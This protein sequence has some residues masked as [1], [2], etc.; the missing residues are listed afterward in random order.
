MNKFPTETLAAE[1]KVLDTSLP[2]YGELKEY[3]ASTENV[4]SLTIPDAK[5]QARRDAQKARKRNFNSSPE[6]RAK[7]RKEKDKE[8]NTVKV[9]GYEF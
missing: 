2:S 3:K 7:Y 8:A 4:E 6:E 1:I 9:G 5:Q